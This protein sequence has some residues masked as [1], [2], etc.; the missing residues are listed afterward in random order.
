MNLFSRN[1]PRICTAVLENRIFACN[2]L[3][4][5]TYKAQMVEYDVDTAKWIDREP[6]NFSK[7]WCCV[8]VE[9]DILDPFPEP[10]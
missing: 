6:P 7:V 9:D 8:S 1:N 5:N 4:F 3:E 10:E 2:G